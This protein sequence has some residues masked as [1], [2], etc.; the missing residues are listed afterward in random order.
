MDKPVLERGVNVQNL[1]R[2]KIAALNEIHDSY[3]R[4]LQIVDAH[5]DTLPEKFKNEIFAE[6][7]TSSQTLQRLEKKEWPKDQNQESLNLFRT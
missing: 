7:F 1:I 6:I 4:M 2:V 5:V 3:C